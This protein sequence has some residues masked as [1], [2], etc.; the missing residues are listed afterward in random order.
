MHVDLACGPAKLDVGV[1][2]LAEAHPC[3]HARAQRTCHICFDEFE[4]AAMCAARCRHFFCKDCWAGYVSTAIS[5]GPSVLSLR[6]PLP[7]C[8]AVVRALA[9]LAGT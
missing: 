6:C 1:Q 4:V 5:S 2:A 3:M 9:A 8:T 7:N